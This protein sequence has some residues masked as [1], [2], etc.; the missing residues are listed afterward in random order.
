MAAEK[1]IIPLKGDK[2]AVLILNAFDGELGELLVW[3]VVF[4]RIA[5]LR[6]EAEHQYVMQKFNTDAL[7][8]QMYE[9][10]RNALRAG[11]GKASIK[12]IEMAVLRDK[13][14]Q[15]KKKSLNEAQLNFNYCDALYWSAQSKDKKL[16]KLTDKLRPEEFEKELVEGAVN[17]ILIKIKTKAIKD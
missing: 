14:F 1:V 4:N 2:I 15:L 8:A 10:H 16:D 12:D 13:V 11:D 9:K 3:P 6:A 7:E 17:G 5:N